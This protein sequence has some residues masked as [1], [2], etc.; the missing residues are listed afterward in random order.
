MQLERMGPRREAERR[1]IEERVGDARAA[2]PVVTFTRIFAYYDIGQVY[3]HMRRIFGF[4][5][6]L[7]REHRAA[8]NDHLAASMS[9]LALLLRNELRERFLLSGAEAM[10]A[11]VTS[12][13][14]PRGPGLRIHGANMQE[15][16]VTQLPGLPSPREVGSTYQWF[17]MERIHESLSRQAEF[18]AGLLARPEIVREFRGAEIDM[19]NLQHR[20]RVWRVMYGVFQREDQLGFGVLGRLLSLMRD[21]LQAFTVHTSYNVRDWGVSY[22]DTEMPID[23]AGR[24]ERDCGV[25]ALMAA[26]EVYRTARD[27]SPR[28]PVDFELWAM[29]DHVTLVIYDRSRSPAVFYV[30]NNDHISEAQ[31]GDVEEI[32][33]RAYGGGVLHA[34]NIVT[35]AVRVP[36][37]STSMGEAA[38]RRQAWDRYLDSASWGLAP[39]PSTGPSDTRSEAERR[40]EAYRQYYSSMSDFD[41]AMGP[42]ETAL[43]GLA[44]AERERLERELARLSPTYMQLARI[45]HTF[46]PHS[47]LIADASRRGIERR[48]QHRYLYV[49]ATAGRDHQL[50]RVAMALQRLQHLGATLAQGDL[51]F[52]RWANSIEDFGPKLLRYQQAGFPARF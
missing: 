38:F 9:G 52:L 48:L 1:R 26:Y 47:Q 21:Y 39:L 4:Y 40:D 16:D 12:V 22:L 14:T 46:G 3:A 37:G 2:E 5:Y 31:T 27:A 24:A 8:G 11:E 20:I 28:L 45:F 35:P 41:R 15:L 29:L 18:T 30:L 43:D 49:T 7:E 13:D 42:L 25:Y 17:T 44:D 51:D 33:A 32:V 34:R 19:N 50:V 10:V 23:L 36:L 6:Q